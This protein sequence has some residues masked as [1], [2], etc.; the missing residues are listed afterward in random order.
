MN[1]ITCTSCGHAFP[2]D[3]LFCPFCGEPKQ[4]TCKHC[5]KPRFDGGDFCPYC[6]TSYS[7]AVTPQ[8]AVHQKEE[9]GASSKKGKK[10]IATWM[11]VAAIVLGLLNV[12]QLVV[13]MSQNTAIHDLEVELEETER[14]L[15][16]AELESKDWQTKAAK[17]RGE[18]EHYQ[19]YA[20]FASDGYY[21]HE[22]YDCSH[23]TGDYYIFNTAYAEW[24][25]YKACPYCCK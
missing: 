2:D 19:G 14:E 25:G 4:E 10:A 7:G 5:G 8:I 1:N 3:S 22:D 18:L 12:G 17:Y 9:Q 13:L 6:G 21:Y 20:V 15:K 16:E 23:F 24:K 11:I